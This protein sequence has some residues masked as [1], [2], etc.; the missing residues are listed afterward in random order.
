MIKKIG[1]RFIVFCGILIS[2]QSCFV[3]QE[4]QRDQEPIDALKYRTDNIPSDT[5]DFAQ[6]SWRK[7]FTDTILQGH[8]NDALKNN[9]DIRIALQQIKA[10]QAFFKQGKAGYFPSLNI[11][12]QYTHQEL[13]PN[14]QFGSFFSSLDQYELNA[15]LSW[16]ADIWGKI[17][18]QER[19]ARANYLQTQAAHKAVKTSLIAQLATAYYQ[20]LALDQQMVVT[21]QTVENRQNSLEVTQAL[22]EAGDVTSVAVSQTKAQLHTAEAILID[23]KNEARLLENTLSILKGINPQEINRASFEQIEVKQELSTGVPAQLLE[24]RPDV[25]QAEFGLRNAFQMKNVAKSQFYPSIT[26]TATGG[27]QSL[28]ISD[29]ISTNSL[30][31]TVIGGLTQPIFNRRQLK[32]ELEVAQSSEQQAYLN[33]E[34]TLLRASREV[35]DALYNFQAAQEK[36]QVKQLEYQA[37]Q[38]AVDDAQIL[39]KNGSINYLEVLNARENSLNTRLDLIDTRLNQLNANVELYRSLGGGWK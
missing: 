38:Q 5:T 35:T 29:F 2:L 33:F 36:Y 30:F 25:R 16:E 23:L 14:S 39:L 20:L 24:N 22:K 13:A 12:G 19:A 1:I 18:S 9:Q 37:Y 10:A 15:G 8:I 21:K 7:V 34:K 26:L 6:L 32:T 4:Y 28:D 3:A 27:L 17:T 31:A 11:N